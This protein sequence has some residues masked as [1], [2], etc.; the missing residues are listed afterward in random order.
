MSWPNWYLRDNVS[1]CRYTERDDG[2]GT[3]THIGIEG[4]IRMA[5]ENMYCSRMS[6]ELRI[7]RA[8]NVWLLQEV[9]NINKVTSRSVIK[10]LKSMF[11]WYGTPDV[12]VTDNEPQFASAE[13]TMFAKMWGFHYIISPLS[14]IQWQGRI[15]RQD[16]QAFVHEMSWIRPVRVSRS[17]RLVQRSVR[18]DRHQSSTEFPWTSL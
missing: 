14:T 13:F 2:R 8:H 3:Q 15:C 18:R 16:S 5:R 4:C 9:E 12:L 11:S 7:A 10:A 17:P 1:W 6:T